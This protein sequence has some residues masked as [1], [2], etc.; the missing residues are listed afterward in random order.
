[1]KLFVV[2][3]SPSSYCFLS[4]WSKYSPQHPVL[5]NPQ[6]M[7]SPWDDRSSFTPTQN[8]KWNIILIRTICFRW[9]TGRQQTLNCIAV[10]TPRSWTAL[11]FFVNAI[12]IWY[13]CS[14]INEYTGLYNDKVFYC[15]LYIWEVWILFCKWI[16]SIGIFRLTATGTKTW[17][18]IKD[19][20]RLKQVI[21]G[22]N[23]W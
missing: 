3:F 20:T 1:M 15:Y 2:Q 9:E 4:L 21:I 14:Q 10:S 6:C 17:T 23:S 13:H 7:F 11:K 5:R 16:I 12:L 19:N 22:L 8:D 18:T